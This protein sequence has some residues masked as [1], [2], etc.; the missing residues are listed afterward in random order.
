M[1]KNMRKFA[2]AAIGILISALPCEAADINVVAPGLI[3]PGLHTLVQRWSQDT[4][5]QVVSKG[6]TAGR[7]ADDIAAG[8]AQ[9]VVILPTDTLSK[10]SDKLKP[11]SQILIG[12]VVFALA[13]KAGAPHPDISTLEKFRAAL[14]DKIVTYNDPAIGSQ[15]GIMVD[16]LLKT[17]PY[18][19]ARPMTAK[20]ETAGMAVADGKADMAIA[21]VGE[22]VVVKGIDIVAPL[23]DGTG[24]TIDMTGAVLANSAHPD[25]ASS[26]LAYLV[27]PDTAAVWSAGGIARP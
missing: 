4:G 13:V 1:E 22:L 10:V 23:P 3:G 27:K 9:D 7:I 5:N 19:R 2:L 18:A 26:L 20:S 6:G 24:L 16:A 12:H 25:E 15:A 8:A 14:A 21:V 17:A 11:G